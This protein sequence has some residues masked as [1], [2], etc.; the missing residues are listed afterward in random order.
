MR[1]VQAS[2][3]PLRE[4]KSLYVTLSCPLK[5]LQKFRR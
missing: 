3:E 4:V 2:V 1:I 5:T